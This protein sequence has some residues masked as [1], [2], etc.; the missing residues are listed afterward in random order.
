[1]SALLATTE[2]ASLLLTV[3]LMQAYYR[4]RELQQD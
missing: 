4:N 1:M 3:P 2:V